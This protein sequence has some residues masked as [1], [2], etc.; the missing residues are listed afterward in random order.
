MKGQEMTMARRPPPLSSST[1]FHTAT[2]PYF[3][4]LLSGV[5]PLSLIAPSVAS[6][7]PLRRVG[8]GDGGRRGRRWAAQCRGARVHAV[9]MRTHIVPSS[10]SSTLLRCW[11]CFGA[12][13]R[14]RRLG[15]RMDRLALHAAMQG[16]ASRCSQCAL[17]PFCLC[18]AFYVLSIAGGTPPSSCFLILPTLCTTKHLFISGPYACH[19][20]WQQLRMPSEETLQK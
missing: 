7:S 2:S 1:T 4:L 14:S 15:G 20:P 6:L 17:L 8:A 18:V 12:G 13:Q 11:A 3:I 9:L 5:V 16:S 10:L 19:P